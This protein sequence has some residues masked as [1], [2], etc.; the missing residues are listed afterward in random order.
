MREAVH[1]LKETGVHD[2]HSKVFNLVHIYQ[3]GKILDEIYSHDNH[4]FLHLRMYLRTKN[5]KVKIDWAQN[6]TRRLKYGELLCLTDPNLK[7]FVFAIVKSRR[8]FI[9]FDYIDVLIE[10]LGGEYLSSLDLCS[11][12]DINNLV[13]FEGRGHESFETEYQILQAIKQVDAYHLPFESQIINMEFI[14]QPP[15]YLKDPYFKIKTE[16]LDGLP[17]PLV[18]NIDE[19][20]IKNQL[21]N[22]LDEFQY[23]GLQIILKNELSILVGPP[24]TGKRWIFKKKNNIN[25]IHIKLVFLRHWQSKSCWK[26][27]IN[28]QQVNQVPFSLWHQQ[29]MP[30]ISFF[31]VF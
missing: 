6:K 1:Y 11:K 7:E 31:V 12:L 18:F 15:S 14:N 13:V 20:F 27:N 16:L 5:K 9:G 26:I 29:M 8:D 30:S 10:G 24:G 19:P 21:Y 25:I 17:T 2:I 4:F 22:V 3:N 28:G 23:K